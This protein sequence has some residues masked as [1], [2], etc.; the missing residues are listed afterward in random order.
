M[1]ERKDQGPMRGKI[2]FT[3]PDPLDVELACDGDLNATWTEGNPRQR[4]S[5][6]QTLISATSRKLRR[7]DII[8]PSKN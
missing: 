4:F 2:G 3:R 6:M 1:R 7:K 8:P 5:I